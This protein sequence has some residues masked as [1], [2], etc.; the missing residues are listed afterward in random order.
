MKSTRGKLAAIV[1]GGM[2]A[3]GWVL[4]GCSSKMNGASTISCERLN[5]VDK[6]GNTVVSLG[7][8]QNGYGGEIV[9]FD[10]AGVRVISLIAVAGG[11]YITALGIDGESGVWLSNS[12]HGGMSPP[13]AR[14]VGWR[15]SISLNAAVISLPMA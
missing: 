2:I 6:K 4:S 14:K 7:A 1:I 12:E 3:V 11:G 10:K 15:N 5:I 13:G 9:V 8:A